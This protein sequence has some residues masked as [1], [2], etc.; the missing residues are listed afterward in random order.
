MVSCGFRKIPNNYIEL[1]SEYGLGTYLDSGSCAGVE[2]ES[3]VEV[4][5]GVGETEPEA[6]IVCL[7]CR[8]LKS[9]QRR[10]RGSV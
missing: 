8:K 10:Q 4:D 7:A 1:G 6:P 5:A 9:P 2:G 3:G